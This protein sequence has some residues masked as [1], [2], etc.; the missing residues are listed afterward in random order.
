MTTK[1]KKNDAPAAETPD[2]GNVGLA[3]LPEPSET[4]VQELSAQLASYGFGKAT[5]EVIE[6]WHDVDYDDVVQ[7]LER[8][9]SEAN[10]AEEGHGVAAEHRT[11]VPEILLGLEEVSAEMAAEAACWGTEAVADKHS[12]RDNPFPPHTAMAAIWLEQFKIAFHAAGTAP[13]TAPLVAARE[14]TDRAAEQRAAIETAQMVME[15]S[16]DSQRELKREYERLKSRLKGVKADYDDV[17]LAGQEASRQLADARAGILPA[18]RALPFKEAIGDD[19]DDDVSHRAVELPPDHGGK[20]DLNCL[21]KGDLQK[22]TGCREDMGMTKGQIEKLKE[23]CGGT[24]IE[25]LEKWQR[26][27]VNWNTSLTGFGEERI[28]QLQDAHSALRTK[29]PMPVAGDEP[30]VETNASALLKRMAALIQ[31]AGD[32]ASACEDTA[33]ATF[34]QSVST[35]AT[36]IMG[37]IEKTGKVTPPQMLALEHWEI[38]VEKWATSDEFGGDV[39]EDDLP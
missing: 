18:Q 13:A 23:A 20:M 39:L 17:V 27:N 24:T 9:D 8:W 10:K 31:R 36:K 29:F 25:A 38:A 34:C 37:T 11:P 4:A 16:L 7:A 14:K 3:T 6:A 30:A 22:Q 32:I 35:E 26:E 2:D 21:K 12:E 15:E 28:T 33:G 5:A 1:R 19:L